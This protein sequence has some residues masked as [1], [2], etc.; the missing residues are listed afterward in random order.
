MP[1]KETVPA[2]PPKL[3]AELE[4]A[5]GEIMKGVRD[6]EKMDHAAREMDEGREE[7]RQRLGELDLAV[8]LIREA[9]DEG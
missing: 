6:P 5:V 2:I 7:I 3:F 9:R 4:E 1:T 8:E